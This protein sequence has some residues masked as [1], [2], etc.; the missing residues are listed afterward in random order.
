MTVKCT[1]IFCLS[2]ADHE[3][4]TALFLSHVDRRLSVRLSVGL[5]IS[6]FRLLVEAVANISQTWHKASLGKGN[7]SMFK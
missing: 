4:S 2:F 6:Q 7:S 3:I 5:K 1:Y